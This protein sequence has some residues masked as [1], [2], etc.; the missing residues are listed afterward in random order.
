MSAIDVDS[1]K[2]GAIGSGGV[3]A[4]G[5]GT[6]GIGTR[7]IRTRGVR[8]TGAVVAGALGAIGVLHAAWMRTPWPLSSPAEVADAVVGVG[9]DQ[10]PTPAMCAEVAVALGAASY[11]VGAR[12]GVLPAAGPR[13]LRAVGTGAVAGVLLARG[14]G[15]LLLF[16]PKGSGRR[17]TRTER[18]ARLDRRYYSPLCLALGAGAA[19]VAARGV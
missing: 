7:G 2:T 14:V 1:I 10:L 9:V 3:G 13:R 12:S 19:V 11:L 6:R 4:R 8:T 15:G 18:F 17:I 16:G 5:V